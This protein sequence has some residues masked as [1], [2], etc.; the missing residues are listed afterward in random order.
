MTINQRTPALSSDKD[1]TDK[2][3]NDLAVN[4]KK[5][6][7]KYTGSAINLL[8]NVE[9]NFTLKSNISGNTLKAKAITSV[10]LVDGT[11]TNA[12]DSA[13]VKVS[14]TKTGDDELNR[15]YAVGAFDSSKGIGY[16][17]AEKA[18]VVARDLSTC[19]IDDISI[20]LLKSKNITKA[21][22]KKLLS[23]SEGKETLIQHLWIMWILKLIQMQSIKVEKVLI[24]LL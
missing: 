24:Q 22:I 8:T 19:A 16:T 20:G 14:I 17:T 13:K 6:Q 11:L 2:T 10:N 21:D 18:T 12:G 3:K 1:L 5:T 15:N 23:I 9:D 7:Y 4:L